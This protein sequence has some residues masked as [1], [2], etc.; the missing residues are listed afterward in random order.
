MAPNLFDLAREIR[1]QIYTEALVSPTGIIAHHSADFRV[2]SFHEYPKSS[3]STIVSLALLSTC[4]QIRDEAVPLF[5]TN[6][7]HV[8]HLEVIDLRSQSFLAKRLR[9]VQIHLKFNMNNSLSLLRKMIVLN[10]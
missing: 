10:Q 5:L 2:F 7:L 4:R 3:L 6:T 8:T 9:K 1:D